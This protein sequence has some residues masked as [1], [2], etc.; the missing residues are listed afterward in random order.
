MSITFSTLASSRPNFIIP[1]GLY[2]AEIESAEM[3]QG[4]NLAKPKYLSLYLKITDKNGKNLGGIYDNLS[5]STSQYVQF[6]ITRFIE[7]LGLAEKLN[8]S[9]ELSDL[10]KIIKTKKLIVDIK[11]DDKDGEETTRSCV[12]IFGTGIYYPL[13]EAK[14]LFKDANLDTPINAADAEDAKAPAET[15]IPTDASAPKDSND[16]FI[17]G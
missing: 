7:A 12:D 8:D 14:E 15:I 16:P 9:F 11:P 5:E 1:K 4:Q 13:S 17:F 6:K 10:C 2:Y 3:K